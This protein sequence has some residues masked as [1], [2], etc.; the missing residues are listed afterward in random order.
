M[1]SSQ[2][3]SRSVIYQGALGNQVNAIAAAP[4]GVSGVSING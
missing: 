3:G 2:K 4:S 1:K